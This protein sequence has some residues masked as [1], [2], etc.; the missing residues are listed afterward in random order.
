[1]P[2]LRRGDDKANRPAPLPRSGPA[3]RRAASPRRRAS[4]AGAIHRSAAR[5]SAARSAAAPRGP[6]A[7]RPPERGASASASATASAAPVAISS[8]VPGLP[9]TA[10]SAAPEPRRD[11]RGDQRA[12]REARLDDQDR[13]RQRGDDPV[14]RGKLSAARRRAGRVLGERPPARGD[15]GV[16]RGVAIG[17]DDVDAAA[18]HGERRAAR[19]ERAPVRGRVDPERAARDNR[20]SLAARPT[21]PDRARAG[22]RPWRRPARRR[23]PGDARSA[24]RQPSDVPERFDRLRHRAQLGRKADLI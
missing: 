3:S 17:I 2:A 8:S 6:P 15:V 18:E 10:S 7:P 1:M 4:S 24:G 11:A 16:Q 22:S 12:G 14:A 9:G 5:P 19:V 21:P 13:L 23:S 20:E